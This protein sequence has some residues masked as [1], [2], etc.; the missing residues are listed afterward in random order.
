MSETIILVEGYHDRAFWKG[1]LLHAGCVD[2]ASA[3]GTAAVRITDTVG[4]PVKGGQFAFRSR[5]GTFIRVQPRHGDAN[6]LREARIRLQGRPTRPFARLVRCL[7]ADVDAAHAGLVTAL[8]AELVNTVRQL[9]PA[10]PADVAGVLRL[11]DGTSV[12]SVVWQAADLPSDLLPDQQCLERLVAA[13]LAEAYP[14]R[15]VAVRDWLRS[16]PLPPGIDPKSHAWSHMAG[17]YAGLGCEAF[18]SELW[19]DTAV[20]AALRTRLRATGAWTVIEDSA[21]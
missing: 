3:A 1:L 6:V 10:T 17:W 4:K 21:A 2:L 18:L 9:E 11:S 20:A 15:A 8:P 12:A 7:D 19:T 5:S 13:S 14:D 16:R